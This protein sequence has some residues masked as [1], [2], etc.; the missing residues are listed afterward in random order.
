MVASTIMPG[1]S[2]DAAS[3]LPSTM[4]V[5]PAGIARSLVPSASERV[6]PSGGRDHKDLAL[7]HG[8]GGDDLAVAAD[9]DGRGELGAGLEIGERD[10]LAARR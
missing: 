10:L 8:D 7:G 2:S 4:K 9:G 6:T 5:V 3:F 1:F